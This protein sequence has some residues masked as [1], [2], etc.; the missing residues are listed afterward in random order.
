[1]FNQIKRGE[2]FYSTTDNI[3]GPLDCYNNKKHKKY[4]FYRE[5]TDNTFDDSIP[6]KFSYYHNVNVPLSYCLYVFYIS[7]DVYEQLF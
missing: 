7:S 1:M 3:C 6:I 4:S 5:M 2:T